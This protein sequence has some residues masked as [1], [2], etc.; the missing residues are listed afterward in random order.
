MKLKIKISP[1][2][3]ENISPLGIIEDRIIRIPKALR[4]ELN[5]KTGNFISL[6]TKDGYKINLQ[7]CKAYLKDGESDEYSAFVS[8]NT[9]NLL[10]IP[11]ISEIK[12]ANDILIGC[13]PEFFLIDKNTNRIISAAHFFPHHGQIGSDVG[14]A[15]VRPRPE[16]KERNLT[17]NIRNLLKNAYTHLKNRVLYK[18]NDVHMIASSCY[19]GSS[20]GFHIHFGL[21]NFFLID[22]NHEL[23][24]YIV[25]ILDYYIG[26]PSI[27][28]E[29]NIDF[30]RRS[31]IHSRYGKPRDY[32]YDD[33]TLEYRVPGGH[34][35]R[36]PVLTSGLISISLVVMKDILSRI[37]AYTDNFAEP[38]MFSD[39]NDIRKL[40]PRMPDKKEIYRVITSKSIDT[41]SFYINDILKDIIRMI[42]FDN[43]KDS[44]IDYFTYFVDTS[45]NEDK[46]Y[47]ED[48]E[49][50]WRL[51]ENA[52]Q[53]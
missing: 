48:I 35:L 13:D 24:S 26:I 22:S 18:N 12:P 5:L 16:F 46:R 10:D 14:L 52:R 8:V 15:E 9:K 38:N 53:P 31:S 4:D 40:Y 30:Y 34:L 42:G 27:L 37:N 25:D 29:G 43:N 28:P 45:S 47:N 51:K 2:M 20:A 6:P 50:N 7:I 3:V 41:A 1:S 32:R 17:N 23:R 19:N 21:P 39:Y 36:H 33:L 11:R 49:T 44:I